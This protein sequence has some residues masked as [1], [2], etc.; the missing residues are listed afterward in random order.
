MKYK[1]KVPRT[2]IAFEKYYYFRWKILRMP[3]G[4]KLGSERDDIENESF[5]LYI[6]NN[7]N[8]VIAVGRIH[9]IENHKELL[10]GQI[11]YM[12]V[13]EKYQKMGLGSLLLKELEMIA[14]KNKADEI[15]LHSRESAINFYKKNNYLIIEKSHLLLNQIQHWL[16]K[17]K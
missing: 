7:S 11:R 9:L 5:H 1:I 13:H 4:G 14:L 16:M 15:I 10:L 8:N 12:A 3:L 2:K 17:K 6:K